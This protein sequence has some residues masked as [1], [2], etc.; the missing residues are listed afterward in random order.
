MYRP[1]EQNFYDECQ[2][3]WAKNKLELLQE[4]QHNA[5]SLTNLKASSVTPESGNVYNCR[6]Y[7]S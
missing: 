2:S 5:L 1:F 4:L 6:G 7:N 3:V